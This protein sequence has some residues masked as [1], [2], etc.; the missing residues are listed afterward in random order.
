MADIANLAGG[1]SASRDEAKDAAK[2]RAHAVQAA[3]GSPLKKH[4]TDPEVECYPDWAELAKYAEEL[5][6]AAVKPL[7]VGHGRI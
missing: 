2:V 4:D 5:L 1:V 7:T 3:R 6:A